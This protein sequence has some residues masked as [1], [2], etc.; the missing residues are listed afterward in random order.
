MTPL[1]LKKN[2]FSLR[3]ELYTVTRDGFELRKA[4]HVFCS[5]RVGL[6]CGEDQHVWDGLYLKDPCLF[7]TF[8][9]KITE[10]SLFYEGEIVFIEKITS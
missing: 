3:R 8:L 1:I 5:W 9:D 10:K 2:A 7:G 4:A 6:G